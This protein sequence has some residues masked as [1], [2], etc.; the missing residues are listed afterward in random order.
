M[1]DTMVTTV[2]AD[3]G[4]ITGTLIL[5]A[6]A[7][8]FI[9]MA[10]DGLIRRQ[11]RLQAF[12]TLR[13]GVSVRGVGALL[14]GL[15]A[16]LAGGVCLTFALGFYL[17]AASPCGGSLTCTLG[18]FRAAE[19]FSWIWLGGFLV[20]FTFVWLRTGDP[21]KR[22]LVYGVWYHQKKAARH[23]LGQLRL[24]QLP[25]LPL[26]H[27]YDLED[28]LLSFMHE[29]GW[30]THGKA[31]L[32]G[33]G[34]TPVDVSIAEMWDVVLRQRAYRNSSESER[35]AIR[36][37]LE[38]FVTRAQRVKRMSRLSRWWVGSAQ[39]GK[40]MTYGRRPI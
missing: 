40:A 3:A 14:L 22:V 19:G 8:P 10:W 4:A 6:L 34:K 2:G 20:W 13:S 21:H 24:Q 17:L 30:L 39:V 25:L 15:V 9:A 32:D 1:A 37:L 16:A 18:V 5:V 33:A 28:Q 26:E 27:L 11:I 12:P 35:A 31:W 7:L 38:Y 29:Q 36:V 23:V